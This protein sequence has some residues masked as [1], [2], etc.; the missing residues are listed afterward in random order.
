VWAG[1]HLLEEWRVYLSYAS[2]LEL[3]QFHGHLIDL[4]EGVRDAYTQA[5]VPGAIS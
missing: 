2:E 3:T 5:A 4:T 1:N